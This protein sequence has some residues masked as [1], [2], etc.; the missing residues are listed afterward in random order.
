MQVFGSSTGLAIGFPELPR[1]PS[2]SVVCFLF[3]CIRTRKTAI[4]ALEKCTQIL[5]SLFVALP[6][7]GTSTRKTVFFWLYF[8]LHLLFLYFCP[9]NRKSHQTLHPLRVQLAMFALHRQSIVQGVRRPSARFFQCF[10]LATALVISCRRRW[11]K[12]HLP[13][14]SVPWVWPHFSS[15]LRIVRAGC[16]PQSKLGPSCVWRRRRK[17]E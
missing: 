6:F 11:V 15:L 8:S 9:T 2:V 12:P 17:L 5:Q 13:R 10:D 3:P 7:E 14:Q 16:V 1:D 4:F